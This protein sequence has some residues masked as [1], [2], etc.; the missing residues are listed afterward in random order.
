MPDT[1]SYKPATGPEVI[2]IIGQVDETILTR[3]IETGATPAE[4][5]EAFTWTAADDQ[6]G[7]ELQRLPTGRVAA[8][9]E[10]LTEDE[11]EESP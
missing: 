3:I 10:I 11:D 8:V 1:Q 6:L 5:L 2:S 4:V 9:Y 7:D